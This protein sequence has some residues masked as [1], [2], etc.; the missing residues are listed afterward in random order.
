MLTVR[1][2]VARIASLH[3]AHAPQPVP[4]SALAALEQQLGVRL[5]DEYRR[6]LRDVGVGPGLVPPEH[7]MTVA[8]ADD[9]VGNPANPFPHTE[10]FQASLDFLPEDFDDDEVDGD[11][12]DEIYDAAEE[13]LRDMVLGGSKILRTDGFLPIA[14][15]GCNEWVALI[16]CGPLVGHV[17]IGTRDG[18]LSFS[19]A[20]LDYPEPTTFERWYVDHLAHVERT[21][22]N[23]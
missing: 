7:F 4:E 16:T 11:E 9:V 6:F 22:A 12:R 18:V 17:W 5:P 19:P 1:D 15:L 23:H 20:A 14:D 21:L 10:T 13:R 3:P 8:V 2:L